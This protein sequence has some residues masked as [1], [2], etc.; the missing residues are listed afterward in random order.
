MGVCVSKCSVLASQPASHASITGNAD[1]ESGNVANGEIHTSE[2]I[3]VDNAST[4][5]LLTPPSSRNE[6][7][8]NV[9]RSLPAIKTFTD[10]AENK[11]EAPI[12]SQW[13]L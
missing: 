13:V 9:F 1:N 4:E 8:S 10:S 11:V 6:L 12:M 2:R 3:E 5:P 7:K